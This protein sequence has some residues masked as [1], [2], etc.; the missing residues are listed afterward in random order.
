MLGWALEAVEEF[1]GSLVKSLVAE[2]GPGLAANMVGGYEATAGYRLE[3]SQ[4]E[5]VL[6][7]AV[8]VAGDQERRV[9]EDEGS[10]FDNP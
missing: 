10:G 5:L 1:H 4:G 3:E 7:I 6:L 9:D 2:P 8:V